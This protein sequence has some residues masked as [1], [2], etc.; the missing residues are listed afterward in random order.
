VRALGGAPVAAQHDDLYD[1]FRHPRKDRP[2]LPLLSPEQA[3][4]YIDEVRDHTLAL[5][6]G[7]A[8]PDDDR[9][10]VDDF[11]YGMVIQHEHQHDETMLATIQ[12]S[13]RP[14]HGA[15]GPQPVCARDM[16]FVDGGVATLGT[17]DEAWAYDNERPAYE[18]ELD[19]FWIDA[20]PVTNAAYATF[21]ADGGY[22]DER[23]WSD[24]GWA[25]R[26]ES[27]VTG[28]LFW[29]DDGTLMRFGRRLPIHATEPV[30]H[31]CWYEADA[32]ARWA[33]KRLPTESEWER[34][35][36]ADAGQVWEWTSSAFTGWPG[37]A[38][39]PYREYSEVFFGSEYM[40]LRGASW[41]THETVRRTTFRNWDYPIRRQIF[42]GF[43][44]ARDADV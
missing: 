11:V 38:S 31:V 30:Q 29:N 39:F 32:F 20:S 8:H 6:D 21:I 40:T 34:A 44:C 26:N 19:A 13:G 14:Y 24:D 12:L 4:A 25:W 23:L 43:R 18:V 15:G 27:G 1:A 42:S 3:R 41:A 7:A 16:V 37:F 5:A 10:L 17:S 35:A 28:P 22:R 36:P 9:L 33:G 2:S